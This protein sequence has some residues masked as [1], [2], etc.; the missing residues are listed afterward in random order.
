M[1]EIRIERA[2]PKRLLAN[3]RWRSFKTGPDQQVWDQCLQPVA[4]AIDAGLEIT[5]VHIEWG[6]ARPFGVEQ[7]TRY[8]TWCVDE[9]EL[10]E[11]AGQ[12][13][14]GHTTFTLDAG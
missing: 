8:L 9:C 4:D 12:P 1:R 2:P 14:R 13:G 10:T 3:L 7:Q 5:R 11:S 6:R